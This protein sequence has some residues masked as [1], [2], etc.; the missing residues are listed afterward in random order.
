[1]IAPANASICVGPT[2]EADG[3]GLGWPER[4]SLFGVRVSVVDYDESVR[5][6]EQAVLRRQPAI[7][8]HMAVHALVTAASDADYRAKVNQFDVVAPD[9]Q[10]VRWALNYL[11]S[12]RLPDRVYG[13]EL[14]LRLCRRAAETGIGVYLYGSTTEVV[15]ALRDNLRLRFPGLRI[16]GCEPSAFR[17]LTDDEDEALV[18]R[19]NASGAGLVFLGLGCPLQERFAH[20]HRDRINA[21]QLCVGAAFDFHAGNKRTAPGWMQR[22]GLEWLFRLGQEP[23]RLWR[24]YLFTNARF[25]L[26]FLR[27]A[28]TRNRRSC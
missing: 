16:V 24:R 5:C 25:C 4:R 23:R 17:A 27:S 22:H 11:E 18:A 3:D 13:P 15:E 28:L 20:E 12:T 2:A 7:V 10:P 14:M 26:L 6:I 21:V 1:M 8:T 9:G 19:I